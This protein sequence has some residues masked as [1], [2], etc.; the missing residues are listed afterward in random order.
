MKRIC[1]VFVLLICIIQILVFI[2][3]NNVY[4][5]DSIEDEP[6]FIAL[7]PEKIKIIY[8][9]VKNPKNTYLSKIYDYDNF[10]E[11]YFDNLTINHGVNVIG[12][13]GYVGIDMLLGYF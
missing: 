7:S 9:L 6:E 12:S 2:P 13:C 11:S 4:A 5:I 3:N 10:M 1:S 8:D